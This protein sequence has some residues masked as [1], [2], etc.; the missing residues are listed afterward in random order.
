M[1][2]VLEDPMIDSKGMKSNSTVKRRKESLSSSVS[3][4]DS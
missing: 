4:S 3:S 1:D 2:S